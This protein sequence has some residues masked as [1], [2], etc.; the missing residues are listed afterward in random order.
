MMMSSN[1]NIFSVTGPLWGESTSHQWIPITKAS[2]GELWCFLWSTPEQTAE[3]TTK[4]PVIWDAIALIMTS[5]QWAL[6]SYKLHPDIH[7][8]ANDLM[9]NY[10]DVK[11]DTTASQ[12]TNLTAVYST[13]YSDADQRKHQ[14]SASQACVRGIH[15]GPVNS[16]H[17][18]PVTRKMFPF[19]D[20]I[21]YGA[22]GIRTRSVHIQIIPTFW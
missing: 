19:L 9:Q 15:R 10:S 12:I 21:M 22:C 13:V 18:C 7:Y 11:I 14:S 4:T 20:D 16:P 6:P 1:G 5:L 3:Q 2:D 17:K 8:A